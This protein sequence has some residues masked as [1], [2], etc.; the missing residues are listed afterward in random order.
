MALL[1]QFILLLRE[2]LR[3]WT[4]DGGAS[5]A[6]SLAYYTIFSLSPLLIV[7]ALVLGVMLDERTIQEGVIDGVR[8]AVGEGGAEIISQLI[9]GQ[10]ETRTDVVSSLVWI[11]VVVWGAS[12]LFAQLQNALNK[13]WEVKPVPGR[14]PTA[15]VKSR[16]FSFMLV[17]LVSL[18]LFATMLVNSSVNSALRASA[19]GSVEIIVRPLQFLVTVALTTLLIGAVFKILPDVIIRWRDVLVGAAFTA[20]LFYIGQ[21]L[22][23]LYLSRSNFSSVFGAAGSLTA[24]LVWIY[25]SAQILLFGAEFTEVWARNY[26]SY[27]RPDDD[28]TWMNEFKARRE[29]SRANVEFHETDSEDHKVALI[30]EQNRQRNER[31]KRAVTRVTPPRLGGKRTPGTPTNPPGD[32]TP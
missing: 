24:I 16:A 1:R 15:L 31:I 25:Y 17:I 14:S 9:S 5:I 3:E 20:I 4:E 7:I 8:T 30:R 10:R 26:G 29:A 23:G 13:I 18:V 32:N 28:A 19:I 11:G 6:A 21:F 27:I 22:V 2:T 12:G